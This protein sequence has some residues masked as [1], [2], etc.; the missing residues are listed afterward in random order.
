MTS[1]MPSFQ[2]ATEHHWL[3]VDVIQRKQVCETVFFWIL[4]RVWCGGLVCLLVLWVCSEG[5]AVAVREKFG[6]NDGFVGKKFFFG[7]KG[8][9]FSVLFCLIN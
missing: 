7:V 5:E 4:T 1:N 2:I 6:F 9:L 8:K 3:D